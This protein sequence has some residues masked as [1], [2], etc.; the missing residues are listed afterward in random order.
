MQ[1]CTLLAAA[2]LLASSTTP[3]NG[4]STS[5]PV[6]SPRA[7]TGLPV[8]GGAVQA[9]AVEV[10]E[11]EADG[12]DLRVA[13]AAARHGL[14]GL[15][16]LARGGGRRERR[17]HRPAASG[18][19]SA[20]GW[21]SSRSRTNT[22]RKT[23]EVS[24][25]S[26]TPSS[27]EQAGLGEDAGP[28]LRIQRHLLE[29]VAGDAGDAVVRRQRAVDEGEGRR[30]QRV[31]LAVA[32]PDHVGRSASRSRR[33]S[34]RRSSGLNAGKSIGLLLQRRRAPRSCSHCPAKCVTIAGARGSS[35]MRLAWSATSLARPQ[36]AGV[37]GR[38]QPVV[39]HRSPQQ[40]GQAR[41]QL[42][43]GQAQVVGAGHRHAAL[44]PV[45][46]LRRQ[47]HH[48]DDRLRC[49]SAK[50]PARLAPANACFRLSRSAGSSGRRQARLPKPSRN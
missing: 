25:P 41:G 8:V 42:P 37:G 29:G 3:V 40:V 46:E 5:V 49:P 13:G 21:H 44:D 28:L 6:S 4:P 48:L 32:L 27:R 45:Q 39:G 50:L 9:D 2:S 38:E 16:P 31:E 15:G 47:Q 23:S 7:S 12:V 35:S 1:S 18:G 22:P 26:C 14:A 19:G 34:S 11:A 20:T 36:L 10:L 24:P 30:Q 33:A 43:G 17:A